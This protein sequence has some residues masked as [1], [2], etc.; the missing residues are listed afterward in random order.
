MSGVAFTIK[1]NFVPQVF[2]P[3]TNA[4]S[5]VSIFGAVFF[6]AGLAWALAIFFRSSF[7][8]KVDI[9]VEQ[10]VPFSHEHHVAGL[11]IGCQYCHT[12]VE[13]SAFAGIPGTH[14]C[15]TCHSQIW[16]NSPM[17]E[18]V[19]ES[20]RTGEPLAWN[21]VNDIAD[22]AYFNHQVHVTKGIGC[23]TCHGRLDQ[24]PL[25]WKEHTLF[26]EWCLD[27]HRAPEKYIRPK[28]E[29]Y[30]MGWVPPEDQLT[31]G[32]QLVEEYDIG[33]PEKMVDCNICHY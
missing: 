10:P 15:M 25:T 11:G 27:C 22:F 18:P 26:M 12:S 20:Y 32:R 23:E 29:V 24:M 5:R 3:S 13:T 7:N 8:T 31:L 14:T 9:P 4:F 2:H 6:I 28:E 21:R 33:P 1:L 16:V 17:L 30:T 19:R